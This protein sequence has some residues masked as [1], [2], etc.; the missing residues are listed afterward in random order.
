MADELAPAVSPEE[1]AAAAELDAMIDGAA[2]VRAERAPRKEEAPKAEEAPAGEPP[3]ERDYEAEARAMGW[4]PKEE[5]TGDPD[6][7]R[8][9]QT[10]VELADNDPAILRKKYDA[11]VKEVEEFQ[12]RTAAATKAQIERVRQEAQDAV[13]AEKRELAR[14]RDELINRYAGNPEAIRQ[15]NR[16]YEQAQAQ[17]PDPQ[18]QIA[19]FE[20]RE[21][22]AAQHAEVMADPVFQASAERLMD[23]VIASTPEAEKAGKTARQVQELYFEKLNGM[24]AQSPAYSRYFQQQKPAAVSNGAPP[25]DMRSIEAPMR[26][27][28]QNPKGFDG[29]P[30]EAKQMYKM[31]TEEGIKISKDEFAKDFHNA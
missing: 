11:K 26:S 28:Q 24:L 16:N 4:K 19:A 14:Q 1:A 30:A 10:F 9:A 12:R 8:D 22:W 27:Q 15:I 13:E 6:K 3:K 31:L 18:I 23:Q 29:L 5:W 20:V 2:P 25:A 17:L 7:H 21:Q